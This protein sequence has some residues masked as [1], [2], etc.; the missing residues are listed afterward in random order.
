ML[1]L[2]FYL[3]LLEPDDDGL[4]LAAAGIGTGF[5]I[6]EN[7]CYLLSMGAESISFIMIRGLAVGVMHIVSVLAL[8]MGLV[9]V[10]RFKALSAP[11]IMG[12]LAVIISGMAGGPVPAG[13][14]A[15]MGSFLLPAQCVPMMIR[16]RRFM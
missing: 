15:V 10:R 12:A 1:P 3:F 4:I 8:A 5:A 7:C 9:L 16:R 6:Y 13:G 14:Q 2:L 11:G